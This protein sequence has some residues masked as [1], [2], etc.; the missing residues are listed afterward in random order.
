M[1]E[2]QVGGHAVVFG[3]PAFTVDSGTADPA[4]TD[5]AVY[6]TEVQVEK[7]SDLEE[8]RNGDGEVVNLTYYNANE[9]CTVTCYPYGTTAANAK[10]ANALPAIGSVIGISG[11]SATEDPDI[12]NTGTT[13]WEK[14][15]TI[16][17]ASKSR[18]QTGKVVWTLNLKRFAGI[19]SYSQLS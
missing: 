2:I 17:G 16:T 13:P 8:T 9:T 19:S 14:S 15:W 3:M 11:E 5:V 1:A 6:I 4:T 18:S 12:S 7:A 10:T